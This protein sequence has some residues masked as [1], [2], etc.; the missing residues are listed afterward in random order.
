MRLQKWRLVGR[1]KRACE[2]SPFITSMAI[3]RL[4]F[5]SLIVLLIA[6]GA[7]HVFEVTK[8]GFKFT[9]KQLAE[10]NKLTNC[11]SRYKLPSQLTAIFFAPAEDIEVDLEIDLA[12]LSISDVQARILDT[13]K[14]LYSHIVTYA[15]G[16]EV[17]HVPHRQSRTAV[18]HVD[19]SPSNFNPLGISLLRYQGFESKPTVWLF[20][21]IYSDQKEPSVS[22]MEHSFVSKDSHNLFFKYHFKHAL[23]TNPNDVAAISPHE[24]Y[25]TNSVTG[26]LA[27]T[28]LSAL[29]SF[30]GVHTGNVVYCNILKKS[31]KKVLDG[32]DYA[33]S[34]YLNH[35]HSKLYVTETMGK[36]FSVYQRDIITSELLLEESIDLGA[37]LDNINV[38]PHNNIWVAGTMDGL[39][40]MKAIRDPTREF[41]EAPSLIFRLIPKT[42]QP[43]EKPPKWNQAK[44]NSTNYWVEIVYADNGSSI[45]PVSVAAPTRLGQVILGGLVSDDTI[46]CDIPDIEE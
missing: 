4:I 21:V 14:R 7:T 17:Y 13:P 2:V 32:L 11:S 38:D 35:D 46:I 41:K 39:N 40:T 33:N 19:I 16:G 6:W 44:Y 1:G 12:F 34:V 3:K 42:H 9:P 37:Y 15:V 45:T 23:I 5:L 30:A 26:P 43:N 8:Y 20:A 22:V 28:P 10:Y 18:K 24:F 29:L 36:R 27:N 31:C 25:V